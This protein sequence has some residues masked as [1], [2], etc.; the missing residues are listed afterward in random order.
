MNLIFKFFHQ[1]YLLCRAVITFVTAIPIALKSRRV[2]LVVF[3]LLLVCV[4]VAGYR[5]LFPPIPASVTVLD[6]L[7]L[8]QGWSEDERQHYY[9]MTQGTLIIPYSWF[10]ALE[11]PPT[12][13]LFGPIAIDNKNMLSDPEFLSRYRLLP[14]L[15][16]LNNPDRLPVGLTKDVIPDKDV[17]DLGLGHKEWLSYSCAACHTGQIVYKG[18]GIRVDGGTSQWNFT[19]FNT[20]LANALL[21]TRAIPS[22]FQRFADRILVMEGRPVNDDG[23]AEIKQ[24]VDLFLKSPV[25]KNGI[26][27]IFQGTYPTVEGFGRMDALGRGAN[28]QFDQLDS[29]NIHVADAPVSIPPVWFTHEYDWVQSPALINQPLGRN[30]TES[31]GVN[32]TVDL[33]SNDPAHLYSST[34]SIYKLVWLE[35]VASL[36]QSPKWP[37]GVFGSVNWESAKRGK[38]LYEEKVF[39]NA[40]SPSEEELWPNPTRTSKGLCARCHAPALTPAGEYPDNK[41]FIQLPMYKLDVLGTDPLDAQNFAARTVLTGPLKDKLFS[42][43]A[44]VGIGEAL[45]L[46]TTQIMQKK[47][48]ELKIPPEEQVA[49]SGYRPNDFRAPLAYPARP[50][51]GYWATAPYLHN[52]SVPNLYQLLSPVKERD[53]EFYIGNP[54]FDPTKVGYSTA[55][56]KNGFLFTTKRTFFEAVKNYFVTLFQGN[57]TF[58]I[59]VAGNSNG[60]HEFRNAP[61]GTPGVIGPALSPQDRMDIIE[62]MKVMQDVTP[63]DPAEIE[64]RRQLLDS[65]APLTGDFPNPPTK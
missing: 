48:I 63:P 56:F 47:F 30:I 5:F 32:A 57:P 61:K 55:Q 43:Q 59:E 27:A 3:G 28:G 10:F 35:T 58:A 38:Y 33:T 16:L 49:L 23:R 37:E 39:E 64:R 13:R 44:Q 45:Q 29:G 7:R 8:D 26:E 24:E 6:M 2:R 17:A 1:I 36:L 51:A 9:K 46:T 22:K 41:R 21:A 12:Y 4:L 40:L 31:W 52:G 18:M 53:R 54:E 14:D 34:Q 42:G 62:Y 60:G 11:Q 19:A 15:N 50:L 65:M 20:L 25:I